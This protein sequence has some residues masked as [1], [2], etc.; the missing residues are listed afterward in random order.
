MMFQTGAAAALMRAIPRILKSPSAASAHDDS[1][2]SDRGMTN[3]NFR[4]KA[5]HTVYV[6]FQQAASFRRHRDNDQAFEPS[7]SS[8]KTPEKV[9]INKLSSMITN[10]N[11]QNKFANNK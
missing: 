4:I 2:V 3:E 9:K 1:R 7:R 6:G 8:S 5:I 11:K 10:E